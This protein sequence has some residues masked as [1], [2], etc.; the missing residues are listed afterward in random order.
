MMIRRIAALSFLLTPALLASYTYYYPA[1]LYSVDT[2][3]WVWNGDIVAPGSGGLRGPGA[4]GSSLISSQT[5][6]KF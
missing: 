4:N 3:K 5:Y 1:S 2:S 6:L